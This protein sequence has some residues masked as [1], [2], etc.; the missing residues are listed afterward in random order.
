MD[1]YGN[2]T[3]E[4]EIEYNNP[5]RCMGN[6]SSAIGEIEIRPFGE[7]V[8]YDKLI[9]ADELDITEHAVLWI[10]TLPSLNTDGSLLV[11]QGEV[12]TPYDYVVKKVGTSLNS[13]SIAVK[14][15]EV[16]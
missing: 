12:V 5:K 2:E 4:F 1:D 15:V 11:E 7:S 14:K 6:I 10:D 3:G 9:I 13:I 16:S 8:D